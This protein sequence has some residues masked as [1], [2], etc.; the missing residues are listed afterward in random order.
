MNLS[1]SSKKKT[2][3]LSYKEIFKFITE[4]NI[5]HI[6][7]SITLTTMSGQKNIWIIIQII[8]LCG[9]NLKMKTLRCLEKMDPDFRSKGIPSVSIRSLLFNIEKVVL[10]ERFEVRNLTEAQKTPVYKG[11]DICI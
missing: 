8:Y 9:F 1:T 6:K 2:H 10:G 7:N 4:K 5:T 3:L 11:G